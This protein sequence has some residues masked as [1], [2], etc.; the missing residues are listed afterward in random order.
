M[1][2]FERAG[3]G[4]AP[5]RY[6]GFRDT[7]AGADDAGVVTIGVVDG[8]EYKTKPGGSCA[9][10]GT[11]ITAFYNVESSDGKRFHVGSS[12]VAKTGDAG[13]RNAVKKA[14]REA[15]HAREAARIAAA[16]AELESNEELRARLAERRS[17]NTERANDSAL[18]WAEW[19]L[20]NAG[21]TGRLKVA[22]VIEK[23][24]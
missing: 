13:L 15:R 24:V 19:M 23:S 20:A 12:C 4:L 11:Y 6:V 7:K 9:Y 8:V 1:H 2:V 14:K 5:F 3:L 21:T 16:R 22:R 18:D 10:C 17:P